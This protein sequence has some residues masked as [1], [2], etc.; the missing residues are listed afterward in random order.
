MT[1]RKNEWADVHAPDH[2]RPPA[3]LTVRAQTIPGYSRF[4]AHHH[5]WAQMVYATAGTLSVVLD[6][7]SFLISP[8]QAAWLPPGVR[9]QVGS[10]LGAE[11]RSLWIARDVV[12]ETMASPLWSALEKLVQ[13]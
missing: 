9:H 7:Q 10:V 13:F 3:P 8:E 12:C 11:Y 6:T 2:A 1:Q 4:P 5:A